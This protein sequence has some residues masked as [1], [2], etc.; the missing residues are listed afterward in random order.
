MNV[1][2]N[3]L[4]ALL[5]R[6]I[7]PEDA[8]LRLGALGAPAEAVQPMH[9]GLDPIVVGLVEQVEKHPNADRL[10]LCRVNDGTEVR[11]V[12]CGAPNVQAGRKYPYARVGV[13]LPGG[14]TLEKKKLRGVVSHGML[15][16]A[17]ELGLGTDHTGIMELNTDASPGTAL[18]DAVPYV[19]TRL[20]LEITPNRPDLLCHKGVARELGAAYG[21]PVKLPAF[22]H[23]PSDVPSAQRVEIKGATDGIE[24]S[25]E[26]K[27]G[28]PRYLAAIVRGVT[29]G[30]SPAWLDARMRAV[31]ARPINNV[32][33]ATNYILYEL[34][35][36]LHAFDLS[37]VRGRA[38]IVRR[39]RAGE[40]ITTLDGEARALS[41]EMTLICDGEGPTA[42]AGVMG[43]A[44]SEVDD[45]T[46]DILLE[47]AYFDP[48]RI[49]K[50]R[51]ALKL[52]T[53]ASYRFERGIDLEGMADALRRAVQ[54]I[55]AVAG[56]KV[57]APPVDVCPL[58]PRQ[59]A[60]FLRPRRVEHF[61]G[62]PVSREEIER[63]LVSIGFATAP[64][65]DRLHVQIPGWRPDVTR[66]VDLIE[67]VARLKGYDAFPVELRP[68][69]PSAVPDDP[70]EP[71]KA[72]LRRLLVGYGVHEARSLPLVPEAGPDQV[73]VLNP[74]SAEEAHLR[75]DLL[76]ELARAVE[77]NWAARVRDVRLF[78]IGTV[79]RFCGAGQ[80]PEERHRVAAV[81][82]GARAPAHWTTSGKAPD[83]DEWD[84][85]AMFEDAARLAGADGRLAPHDSGW[86][87]LDADGVERGRAGRLA[88]DRPAWAGP[89]FG[90]EFEL[91]APSASVRPF[92]PLPTTPPVERDLALVVPA[93]VTVAQVEAVMT[94][95]A[96][97]L[98]ESTRVFDEY[99]AQDFAGRSVAWQLAFRSPERTL[100]DDE[101]DAAID[102][103]LGRLEERLHV[104]RRT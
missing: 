65:D 15:C 101:V 37:R 60:V 18:L 98:L 88:A 86:R 32:V 53:E 100:T 59:R 17:K 28:C 25:I 56:G 4:S 41:P 63:I 13:T 76:P 2:I 97:D 67:E 79:F 91:G 95:A 55:C 48:V 90:F 77:R 71:H 7:D 81:L 12:V 8:A 45:G 103:V 24:I 50:T 51:K 58:P 94:E 30:P 73:A 54:L 66:E 78:E 40:R 19:D 70:I 43:G 21:V 11:E 42:I 44:D 69:R 99:R 87:L 61:L 93:A 27:E 35:Q 34:N 62:V 57:V 104:K 96:G 38:I 64:K 49:R 84:L 5:G 83:Y 9:G 92:E 1:S 29:I 89:L 6:E 14:F 26:D 74:M 23:A 22:S 46:T 39:A 72:R 102:R 68:Y 85:K 33:D 36:P 16:S 75:S 80:R 47:C 10:T 3:W 82:T 52:S 31:G 20:V